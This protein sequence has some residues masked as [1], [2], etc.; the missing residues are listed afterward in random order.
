MLNHLVACTPPSLA[1]ISACLQ[2]SIIL[3]LL[4]GFI[5]LLQQVKSYRIR[6]KF[7]IFTFAFD[8]KKEQLIE[9]V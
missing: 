2:Y 7:C 3:L 5:L 9:L 6:Y 4:D 1:I 8:C